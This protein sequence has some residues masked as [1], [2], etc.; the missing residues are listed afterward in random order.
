MNEEVET[1]SKILQTLNHTK[2]VQIQTYLNSTHRTSIT[3]QRRIIKNASQIVFFYAKTPENSFVNKND[4]HSSEAIS[5][6][7]RREIFQS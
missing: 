1:D 7:I 6:C 2:S 4:L 3:T 5:F